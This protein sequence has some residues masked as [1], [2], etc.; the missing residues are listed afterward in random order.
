METCQK[1]YDMNLINY[2]DYLKCTG[3]KQD[4]NLNSVSNNHDY[5]LNNDDSS[6]IMKKNMNVTNKLIE[7]LYV[8]KNNILYYFSTSD[9]AKKILLTDKYIK[10]DQL[11][12]EIIL[13]SDNSMNIDNYVLRNPV[14]NKYLDCDINNNLLL[15]SKITKKNYFKLIT[16]NVGGL[17]YY[18]FMFKRNNKELYL[19]V[20]NNHNLVLKQTNSNNKFMVNIVSNKKSQIKDNI[21]DMVEN[22]VKEYTKLLELKNNELN[23][24]KILEDLKVYIIDAIDIIFKKLTRLQESNKISISLI[25][26]NGYRE[27]TIDSLNNN[28][29]IKLNES[30]D[31][32]NKKI[33]ELDLNINYYNDTLENDIN[34]IKE[35]TLEIEEQVNINEAQIASFNNILE[36]YNIDPAK[37]NNIENKNKHILSNTTYNNE[38]SNKSMLNLHKNSNI[39]ISLIILLSIVLIIQLMLLMKKYNHYLPRLPGGPRSP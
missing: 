8:K 31:T 10:K 17:Y 35:K 38:F 23:K 1:M 7:I 34:K 37:I 12:F 19:S 3:K 27:T 36:Q 13:M 11:T 6:L 5:G 39:Y 9:D 30:L 4:I 20:D 15:S 33:A 24:K 2:H 14:L 21:R 29:F 26:L 32:I 18:K 16:E 25:E 28:E 22:N